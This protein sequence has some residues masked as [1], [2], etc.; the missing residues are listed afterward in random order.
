MN[1]LPLV[2]RCLRSVQQEIEAFWL[3]GIGD[4]SS[5]WLLF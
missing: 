5:L 4:Y 1:D 3:Q 2:L